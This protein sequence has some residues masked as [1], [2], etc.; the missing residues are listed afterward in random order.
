MR[1]LL[2]RYRQLVARTR[3]SVL[4]CLVC[5]AT[6]AAEASPNVYSQTTPESGPKPV[7]GGP[8]ADTI[9]KN[10]DDADLDA[11]EIQAA[12]A[13]IGKITIKNRNIFDVS[14]PLDNKSLFR[15]ANRLHIKTKPQVIESLLLFEPG[16]SF[17]VRLA[18]E[19]ERILRHQPYLREA[20][21]RPIHFADG[22]VN[23][24][25]ETIDVWTFTPEISLGREG[26]K[27]KQSFGLSEQNLLGFGIQLGATYS[28]TVDR[29]TLTFSFKDNDFL[30]DRYQI[31]AK[32]SDSDDG[33][34]RSFEF[35][36][37]F[38]AL[39]RQRAG[40]IF[41]SEGRQID[42]LYD[43][44]SVIAEFDHRF[45]YHEASLG[46]SKGLRNGWTRRYST[47]IAY[48]RDSFAADP[49]SLLPITIIPDDREFFYPFV[50]FELIEDRFETTTNFD[51]INRTE[52]RFLGTWLNARVGYSSKNAGSSNNSWHYWAAF[53]DALIITRKTSLTIASSFGGRWENNS[54]QNVLLSG[55]M[56]FHRRFND[57]QLFYTSLSASAGKN[58]DI[59]KPLF[60]GGET[61]LRGYPLRY[62]NGDSK[63]LLTLEQRM[64]SN[65]YLFRLFHVGGALFFDAGK[66]WGNSPVDA[67]KFGI[68][69]DVG[70]GLRLGNSRSSSG[71]VLHIDFAFPLDGDQEID[72]LQI[73]VE[74][75]DSF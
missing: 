29:N 54:A 52:D 67:A 10:G 15:L 7:A 27:S 1:G 64:F 13:V 61:G 47:G 11:A 36:K 62:Q 60:L 58:L 74:Y 55:E 19:S 30:R 44:G 65:Y 25:V 4:L 49:S 35:G 45:E 6:L 43:L 23:L 57:R 46:K 59:D 3:N 40:R 75:K 51:Q 16:D 12:Q 69:K 24:E 42:Q 66:V 63:V 72:N 14:N 22:V 73:L 70:F 26:G 68:L 71:S 53:N 8:S 33:F 2:I 32:Y 48:S 38:Y 41:Y 34:F 5:M 37:P 56:R 50:N 17:S 28:S 21:V 20:E 9:Q 39:D 31:A 18:E